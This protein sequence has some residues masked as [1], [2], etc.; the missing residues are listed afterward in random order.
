MAGSTYGN[1]FRVTT[2]GES[3]GNS[4]GA[5]IDGC[6]A[7][8]PLHPMDIQNYLNRRK[9]GQTK[10]STPRVET[11]ECQILSGIF[12]GKT[13]GTPI[14]VMVENTSQRSEDYNEIAHYYRPGHADYTF[15]QKYG[16]RDYRGGGRSSGRETIARV[17]AGAIAAKVLATLNI[18]VHAFVECIGH[19]YAN[20]FVLS[21]REENPFCMPDNQAAR[22]VAGY[23]SE[24]MA[25]QD[26]VGGIITCLVTGMPAG[27]GEPVFDKLDSELAK[28]IMSIGAVKGVELGAGFAV[29][30]M[31]GSQNNDI[32]TIS[33]GNITKKSNHAGGILGGL[34]DGSTIILKAAIKPTSSIDATQQT[35]TKEKEEISISIQGRHDPLIAPR[36]VVVVESMAA[37]TILDLLL[38]GM[39]AKIENLK[40]IYAP[41][42]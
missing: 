2:F 36:A 3:H 7:G 8:V 38:R 12:D 41:S 31:T 39:S 25:K 34:S 33:N 29:A 26:S 9:P 11:D 6:P 22:I 30:Q 27:I 37:I 17:I 13:T 14:M 15:D 10:F 19:I 4:I 16:F 35:V 32:F 28:A 21:E 18:E 5:I 40:K 42:L 24:L 1:L 23:V 20:R